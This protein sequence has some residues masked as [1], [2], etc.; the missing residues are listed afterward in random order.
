MAEAEEFPDCCGIIVLNRF[1]GGHPSSDPDSCMTPSACEKF[2]AK[3]EQAYYGQRAGLMAVLSEPQNERIGKVFTSRRWS[4][5]REVN[6]CRTDV[7]LY[8]Y[9]R[10]M[11]PTA[12]REKRIFG[13]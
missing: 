9:F 10:D 6:N 1:K 12:A 2:L 4:L 13:K 8:I 7:K 3:S 11:N 5:L